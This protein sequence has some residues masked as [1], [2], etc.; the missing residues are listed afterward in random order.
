MLRIAAFNVSTSILHFRF[1]TN[2]FAPF[3]FRSDSKIS[4][5]KSRPLG[6]LLSDC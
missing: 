5:A 1:I 6:R 3:C 2:D 4:N